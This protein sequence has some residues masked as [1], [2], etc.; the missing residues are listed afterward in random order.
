[1]CTTTDN[2]VL[3]IRYTGK[4][5]LDPQGP[6]HISFFDQTTGDIIILPADRIFNV[7]KTYPCSCHFIGINIHLYL[8]FRCSHN[9]SPGYFSEAFKTI[10]HFIGILFQLDT[11]IV[12]THIH[13]HDR[14]FTEG[15]FLYIGLRCQVSGQIGLGF[16]DRIFYFLFGDIGL[17]IRIK[18]NNNKAVICLGGTL[19]F[20][21]F[22]SADTF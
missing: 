20:Y 17:Y 22:G 18:L 5:S 13:K 10:L 12:T 15:E 6:F 7:G 19:Y 8:S 21:Y 4:L 9:F 3:H 16:V 2:D 14:H 1:M 11:V